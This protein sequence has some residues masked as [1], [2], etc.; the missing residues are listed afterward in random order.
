M[1]LLR[2]FPSIRTETVAHFLE[3]P[4]EGVV[5]Q[6]YGAGNMPSNRADIMKLLQKAVERGVLIVTVTQCTHGSVSGLYET[7]GFIVLRRSIKHKS[8]ILKS[9][10]IQTYIITLPHIGKALIDIGIVPGSDM[11]RIIKNSK[12]HYKEIT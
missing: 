10:L 11:V 8:T 2:L 12:T 1:V 5:L 7:G 4:I 9:I 3:P 6:C